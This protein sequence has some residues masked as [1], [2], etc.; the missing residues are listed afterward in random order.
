MADSRGL[1]VV[2]LF[3]KAKSPHVPASITF[4]MTRSNG[5]LWS[6]YVGVWERDHVQQYLRHDG[7]DTT[8]RIEFDRLLGDTDMAK[9]PTRECTSYTSS[10]VHQETKTR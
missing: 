10:P 4:N 2:Q 7:L 9:P 3:S 5:I 8:V 6:Y 1:I